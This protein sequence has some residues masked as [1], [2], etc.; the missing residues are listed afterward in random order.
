MLRNISVVVVATLAIAACAVPVR[1]VNTEQESVPTKEVSLQES[2]PVVRAPSGPVKVRPKEWS[3]PGMTWIGD[4]FS[5]PTSAVQGERL[6]KW[7][8]PGA[9]PYAG[10]LGQAIGLFR[11]VPKE[12]R[13]SWQE[14]FK[15]NKLTTRPLSEG[16]RFCGMFYTI[17]GKKGPYHRVWPN[18]RTGAWVNEPNANNGARVVTATYGGYEWDLVIPDICDNVSYVARKMPTPVPH[19]TQS[20]KQSVSPMPIPLAK[21]AEDPFFI[22]VNYW[23]WDSIPEDLQ[24]KIMKIVEYEGNETY[25]EEDGAVSR[26]LYDDL[27]A[28]WKEGGATTVTVPTSASISYPG[29]NGVESIL[30][31]QGDHAKFSDLVYWEKYI[32]RSLASE[33][34]SQVL[35]SRVSAEGCTVVYPT[36][37]MEYTISTRLNTK[38]KAPGELAL[39][40]RNPKEVGANMNVVL[41]C[42]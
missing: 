30:S 32:S 12:V 33:L 4:G 7:A 42:P 34:E 36:E 3:L 35:L 38:P 26:D 15:M 25:A 20:V 5:C 11:D 24:K 8:R 16:E 2:I 28:S 23:E 41:D 10:T 17:D 6:R 14:D 39:L 13:A 27:V 31:K 21:L 18:V 22:R 29:S 37:K 9:H 40:A 19:N 1:V